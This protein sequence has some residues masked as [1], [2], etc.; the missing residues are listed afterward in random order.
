MNRQFTFNATSSTSETNRGCQPYLLRLAQFTYHP[1]LERYLP[2]IGSLRLDIERRIECG[3][4]FVFAPVYIRGEPRIAV[5]CVVSN[6]LLF[7]TTYIRLRH[8]Y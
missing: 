8:S 3:Y 1:L 5:V 4:G 7:S 6:A 2:I